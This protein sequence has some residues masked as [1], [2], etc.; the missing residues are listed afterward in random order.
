MPDMPELYRLGR[1]RR[2]RDFKTEP[3]QDFGVKGL[4]FEIVHS[5]VAVPI[6][7]I[8]G[9]PSPRLEE[10]VSVERNVAQA[11]QTISESPS[12]E[13][14]VAEAPQTISESPSV[15]RNVAEA[16]HSISESPSVEQNVAAATE[17]ISESVS[18]TVS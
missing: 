10:K 9:I 16:P 4:S 13:R 6:S 12:V 1:G 18:V 17:T 7:T 3:T 11:S 14:Y 5:G 2:E 8:G 15:E